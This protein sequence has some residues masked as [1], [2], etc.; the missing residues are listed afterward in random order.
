MLYE[1]TRTGHAVVIGAGVMGGGIAALLSNLG[2]RVSLL[3]MVPEGSGDN[4]NSQ[5]RLAAEGLDRVLMARPPLLALPEYSTRVRVGNTSDN[6]D[7]LHDADWVVEAV[8]EIPEVKRELMSAI[9]THVGPETVISSNTSGLSLAAMVADCPS[10]FRARFLGTHFFNPPRYMKCVE[11]APTADTDPEVFAGFFRFADRVLGKRVIRAKDTPGFISTRLGMYNLV[12]T[13]ELAV[14]HGMTV[15]Q[16]DYLTGPL[17]GRPRSGTFRLADVIGIDITYRIVENL[18]ATL[19]DDPDYQRLVVPEQVRS[20]LE[21]RRIG[22]KVGAGFYKREPNGTILTLDLNS[23]EYRARIEPTPL[24]SDIERLP[25]ATRLPM[26]T[27]LRDGTQGAFLNAAIMGGLAY[28][29]EVGA[30]IAERIIEVDDAMIGGFGWEMGPFHILD[31]LDPMT[32]TEFEPDLIA[33]LRESGETRFY[34]NDGGQHYYFD[35]DSGE[36]KPLPRPAGVI[37]LKDLKRAGKTIEEADSASL[38]DLDDGVACLEW[39]TKMN[40]LDPN[41]VAF[42]DRLRERAE[43]DFQALVIGGSGEHFS[44]GFNIK[45]F[46]EHIEAKQWKVIDEMLVQFQQALSRIRYACIPV[47]SAVYGYTL[48][49][50]CEIMLHSSAVQAAFESSIGLPEANVGLVPAGGGTVQ[51]TIRAADQTPPETMFERSDPLPY[52]KPAWD[53]LRTGQFSSSADEAKLLGFLR[54]SDGITQHPDRLLHD[55]RE[56]AL[57]LAIDYHPPTSTTISA[58]GEDGLARLKWDIHLQRRAEQIT[59]HDAQIAERLAYIMCGGDVIA[60]TEVSE[61]YLLDLE[62][63]AFLSLGGTPETLARIR[64]MLETGRPLRN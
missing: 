10:D 2:W 50:G 18:S 24:P 4:L 11:L 37:V 27:N 63:E 16:V 43:K 14:Q 64:H 29:A 52:L 7:W 60:G 26:L 35:F 36:M 49:G 58:A 3:D 42:I 56:R 15:E 40:V 17:I 19:P 20:M 23:G 28:A 61:N 57:A 32:W 47:V 30:N 9:A 6:L 55:A 48:G 51:R 39:H 31:T 38:I 62:R 12:K 33:R 53:T 41:V 25:L 5:N 8:A 34:R 21:D 13:I 1:K 44:A 54:N 22:A 45:L 46:A 59:E